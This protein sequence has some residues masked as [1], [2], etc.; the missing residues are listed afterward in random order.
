MKRITKPNSLNS[1]IGS[2]YDQSDSEFFSWLAKAPRMAYE[3]ALAIKSIHWWIKGHNFLK[4]HQYLDELFDSAVKDADYF[5]ELA[6]ELDVN[7]LPLYGSV[8]EYLTIAEPEPAIAPIDVYEGLER[9]RQ[10]IT[11]YVADLKSA[12]ETI[13]SPHIKAEFD[14][15]IRFWEKVDRYFLRSICCD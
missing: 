4:Y 6:V 5:G 14:T 2:I 15:I 11:A 9:T 7:I 1:G 8:I 10:A 13:D 12:Y 3:L